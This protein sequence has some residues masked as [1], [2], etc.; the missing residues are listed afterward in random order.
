MRI[1]GLGKDDVSVPNLLDAAADCRRTRFPPREIYGTVA[2]NT[3]IRG[4][5]NE[6]I[7]ALSKSV[8]T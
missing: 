6:L 7:V 3:E 8:L 4:Q 2:A 5:R 1:G